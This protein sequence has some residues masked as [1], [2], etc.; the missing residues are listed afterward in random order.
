MND[1]IGQERNHGIFPTGADP[2]G[3]HR[4]PTGPSPPILILTLTLGA[5]RP[6][7]PPARSVKGSAHAL[8]IGLSRWPTKKPAGAL[9]PGA[10]MGVTPLVLGVNSQAKPKILNNNL[11]STNTYEHL[12]MLLS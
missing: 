3:A 5:H 12:T 4:T 8:F 11:G 6:T 10:P 1:G 9:A 2:E 7:G